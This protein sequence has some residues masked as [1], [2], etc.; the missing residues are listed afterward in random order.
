[1]GHYLSEMGMVDPL[2]LER[3][4]SRKYAE[5]AWFSIGRDT[6]NS[7]HKSPIDCIASEVL[8]AILA[9]KKERGK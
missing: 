1:M 6:G 3:R 2:D 9:F 5:A 4:L 8:N 7:L